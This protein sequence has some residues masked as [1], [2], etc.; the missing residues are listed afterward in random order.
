MTYLQFNMCVTNTLIVK[1]VLNL[2]WLFTG[3]RT[4]GGGLEGGSD[5]WWTY[6][7][8]RILPSWHGSSPGQLRSV[9]C[10]HY[11]QSGQPLIFLLLKTGWN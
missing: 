11:L 9:I 3:V 5:Q 4:E 8:A 10:H 2:P 7:Q 1:Q 6:G